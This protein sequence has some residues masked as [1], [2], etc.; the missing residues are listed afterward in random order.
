M[1]LAVMASFETVVGL[2]A[3]GQFLSR[4]RAAGRRLLDDDIK[5]GFKDSRGR[6]F[7]LSAWPFVFP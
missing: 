2:P 3:A 6:G 1:V 7:E 4:T 5:A